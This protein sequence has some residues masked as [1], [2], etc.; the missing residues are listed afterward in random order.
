MK[1]KT[2]PIKSKSSVLNKTEISKQL[3][4]LGYRV[5]DICKLPDTIAYLTVNPFGRDVCIIQSYMSS[6]PD[7]KLSN[8]KILVDE[9]I[10]KPCLIIEGKYIKL[11]CDQSTVKL[12]VAINNEHI[13]NGQRTFPL[14]TLNQLIDNPKYVA[15]S[16][17]ELFSVFINNKYKELA[18]NL[19]SF[20]SLMIELSKSNDELLAQHMRLVD[21]RKEST[22]MRE[23]AYN[24]VSSSTLES[25]Y[26]NVIKISG[27]L[28]G[29][30]NE[31]HEIIDKCN[32]INSTRIQQINNILK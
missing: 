2:Q 24:H 20:N 12:F 9:Y 31:I 32:V 19:A 27:T 4:A 29:Q 15:T 11:V 13:T 8:K 14:I 16:V 21:L 17:D 5:S 6:E 1:P 23:Q 18:D 3:N 25:D 7:Y 26:E 28:Q 10:V 22:D 30:Y